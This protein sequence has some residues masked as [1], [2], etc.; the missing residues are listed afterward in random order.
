[1][2]SGVTGIHFERELR[3]FYPHGDL[4][5]GLLGSVDDLGIGRG[6]IEQQFDDVLRGVAGREVVARDADGRAIPGESWL[7]RQP[8]RGKDVVLTIDLELQE[9]GHQALREAMATTGAVGGD[10]LIT[11][12]SSGEILAL[13]SLGTQGRGSLSAVTTPYEP[14][15]TLKPFTVAALLT[16]GLAA[17]GDSVN[18]ENGAWT[19]GRRTIT[20]VHPY[21][22]IT[23]ADALRVSSNIGIAKMAALLPRGSHYQY[24]RDFGFGTPTGVQLPGES[25][26]ILRRP[27]GWSDYS[28]SSLAIGYEI[29]VT[30]MQMA[31]AYGALANGGLLLEPRIVRE[32]RDP[33]GRAELIFPERIVRRVV[34]ATVTAR[35]VDVLVDVVEEGTAR[36]ASLAH[37]T[38]AGKTGTSRSHSGEGYYERGQYQASFVGF[39]PAEAPQLVVFVKLDRP[40]GAYYGGLTAA[41]VTRATLEAVLA[42]RQGPLNRRAL[43]AF[44]PPPEPRAE[45]VLR[46]A[47]RSIPS[48]EPAV[49]EPPVSVSRP[50]AAGDETGVPIPDVSG[51]PAR[52]AVRRLHALGLRV[53]WP[54]AGTIVGTMPAAGEPARPG[55][56]V[57]LQVKV[58]GR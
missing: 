36:A 25:A 44:N 42:A 30:P 13:V 5:Q 43:A 33:A 2:L 12:P 18:A 1:A 53:A 50:R 4:A 21:G 7:I 31:M 14:G 38:V 51:L 37:F 40:E 9:I 46:F 3:R 15:S 48:A 35:L 10:L 58:A 56:I 57:R 32:V 52:I 22:T 19:E 16:D 34:P 28:T 39:F 54:A 23:L 6:G 27:S 26:G 45:S 55:A 29:S 17:L 41:P 20:D 49:S 47:S 11:D 8:Q 24:L